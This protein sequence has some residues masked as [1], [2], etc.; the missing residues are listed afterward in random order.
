MYKLWRLGNSAL[1]IA[2][3][4]QIAFGGGMKWLAYHSRS[5][6]YR[7]IYIWFD[8]GPV[9]IWFVWEKNKL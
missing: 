5:M 8:I 4:K 2:T 6:Y 1:G 7:H 3:M 9:H